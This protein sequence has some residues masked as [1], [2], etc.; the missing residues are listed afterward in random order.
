MKLIPKF[1]LAILL[2][3]NTA[4][5]WSFYST[6]ER[7]SSYQNNGEFRKPQPTNSKSFHSR[8]EA[9]HYYR[10]QQLQRMHA[11]QYEKHIR[12]VSQGGFEE[13]DR[14][15]VQS[16]ANAFYPKQVLT[17]GSGQS[18]FIPRNSRYRN[19][20]GD[21]NDVEPL[22]RADVDFINGL[23]DGLSNE[24]VS[25]ALRNLLNKQD[26][27]SLWTKSEYEFLSGLSSN[28]NNDQ[29][30]LRLHQIAEKRRKP[31]YDL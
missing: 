23:A 20:G 11:D 7:S 19:S 31:A 21:L 30:A 12:Q 25:A 13:S 8:Q 5:A 18:N 27:D 26:S 2:A 22:S 24:A 1:C 6:D 29:A 17:S 15:A 16:R 3:F 4:A 14:S 9:V 10:S 28:I